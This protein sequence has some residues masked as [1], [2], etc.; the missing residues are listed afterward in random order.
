MG[1]VA[2]VAPDVSEEGPL[3]PRTSRPLFGLDTHGRAGR[4]RS[5]EPR[6]SAQAAAFTTIVSDR[7]SAARARSIASRRD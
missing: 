6:F 5:Q 2:L 4:P 1:A 3:G 7:P